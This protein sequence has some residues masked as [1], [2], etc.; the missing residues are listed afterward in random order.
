MCVPFCVGVFRAC[1]PRL[2][3][4][5]SETVIRYVSGRALPRD[6]GGGADH[7]P[8]GQPPYRSSL[9]HKLVDSVTGEAVDSSDKARGY[10]VGE[11]EF[12]LVEDRDLD[13]ARSARPPPGAVELAEPPR[14]ESPPTV[15]AGLTRAGRRRWR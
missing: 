5:L 12:L 2:L 7:V 13:R 3:E 1:V 6:L 10:E 4:G 9:R 11:N 8:A 14:R 15:P